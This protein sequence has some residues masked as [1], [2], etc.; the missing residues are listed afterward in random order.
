MAVVDLTN[1]EDV[2]TIIPF[3]PLISS[4]GTGYDDLVVM[5]WRHPAWEF[6][7]SSFLQHKIVVYT[8]NLVKTQRFCKGKLYKGNYSI[9]KIGILPAN[10]P[11]KISLNQE[12]EY[13][14]LYLN[15]NIFTYFSHELIESDDCELV[16]HTAIDDP[17]IFSIAYLL[18]TEF[19]SNNWA[20]KLFVESLQNRLINHLIENYTRQKYPTWE[21][22]EGLPK[23]KFNTVINYINDYLDQDL[24]LQKLS[25]QAGLSAN[26]FT[27]LFK[28][29]TGMTPHKYVEKCRID[30][31]KQLLI[32]SNL[33]LA[34]ISQKVGFYDQSRFT[35]TFR[36]SLGVT[37][38]KYRD[39]I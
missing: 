18:K 28:N 37:P 31:A 12:S 36:K 34:E 10:T 4:A 9:G 21:G 3:D 16:T 15:P 20:D 13:I 29:S 19:E 17:I 11:E 8:G 24:S 23:S 25:K 35:T 22:D 26:H 2:K 32:K 30:K 7:E 33:P 6:P 5:H 38:K 39:K 27:R 1:K 14:C